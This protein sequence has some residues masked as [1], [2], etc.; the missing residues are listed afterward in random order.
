MIENSAQAIAKNI[1][2]LRRAAGLSQQR[3]ADELNVTRQAVSAWER[4]LSEPDARSLTRLADLYGCG[5]DELLRGHAEARATANTKK[6]KL[7]A[8]L[9]A[10]LLLA[11]VLCEVRLEPS[12]KEA[13]YRYFDGGW[14]YA[15]VVALRQLL[16]AAGGAMLAFGCV[17]LARARI[18]KAAGIAMTALGA[19]A[20]SAY[21]AFAALIFFSG[22]SMPSAVYMPFLYVVS[23]PSLLGCAGALIG[24][25]AAGL[26]R[27]KS[28]LTAPQNS[29]Q[30]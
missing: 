19:L 30:A 1:S 14:Y 18:A 25:G 5:V 27:G 17:S 7:C 4:G 10:A 29:P 20:F 2:R 12:I 13:Y 16:A 9:G 28:Q 6:A 15:Y 11:L 26:S 8:A 23:H 22:A 24:A 3:V 21:A